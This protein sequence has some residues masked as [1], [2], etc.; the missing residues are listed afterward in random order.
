MRKLFVGFLV[1]VSVSV[2]GVASAA[3]GA[4]VYLADGGG[5]LSL[6]AVDGKPV[7]A[8]AKDPN[9]KWTYDKTSQ[10]FVSVP[11]GQCL[12]AASPVDGVAV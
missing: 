1:L 4:P 9:A 3:D 5:T 11:S 12:T 2:P 6:A 8:D 7:L 10:H